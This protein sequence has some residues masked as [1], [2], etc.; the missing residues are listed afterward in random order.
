MGGYGFNPVSFYYCFEPGADAAECCFESRITLIYP[1]MQVI[2]F[3]P[4]ITVERAWQLSSGV[5]QATSLDDLFSRAEMVTLHV[6]LGEGT[7]AL[8]NA[9]R[10]ALMKPGGVVLNFARGGVVDE[11]AVLAEAV[12]LPSVLPSQSGFVESTMITC[13]GVLG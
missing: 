13:T 1:R 6:P 10:L 3:D 12:A 9:D 4:K 7:R 5:R 11:A 2:G 8:V